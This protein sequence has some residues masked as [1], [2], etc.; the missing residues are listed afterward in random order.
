MKLSA[1]E[2]RICRKFGKPDR[3]GRVHCDGCPLVIDATY[4]LCKKV[5]TVEEWIEFKTRQFA[6]ELS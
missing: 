3:F 1:D 6:E 5:C 4:C 2:K